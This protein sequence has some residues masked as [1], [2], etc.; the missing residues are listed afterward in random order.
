MIKRIVMAVCIAAAFGISSTV[1]ADEE[2]TV[3][4]YNWSDYID[5]EILEQ[6]EQEKR[7]LEGMLQQETQHVLRIGAWIVYEL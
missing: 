3:N 1:S 5:E 4:V 2:K 6:F 7:L